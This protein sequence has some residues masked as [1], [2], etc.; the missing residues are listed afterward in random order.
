M[1]EDKEGRECASD[2]EVEKMSKKIFNKY[3]AA[4]EELAKGG[5]YLQVEDDIFKDMT[6]DEIYDKS[7]KH[8]E[9]KK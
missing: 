7:K 6:L 5:D 2:I 4:F 1:S 9:N 3:K 8:S